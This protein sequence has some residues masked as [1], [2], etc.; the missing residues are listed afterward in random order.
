MLHRR[1]KSLL[2]QKNV[3]GWRGGK[4][5]KPVTTPDIRHRHPALLAL[6]GWYETDIV[7]P[8]KHQALYEEYKASGSSLKITRWALRAG[9]LDDSEASELGKNLETTKFKLSCRHNDLIRLAETSH[10]RSC[11]DGGYG[12]QQ[13]QYLADPDIAVVFIPDAAGKYS[14]RSLA[15]LV[16]E[17][18]G[19]GLV[20]YR[21]YGNGPTEAIFQT[22]DK[23]LPVYQAK[24]L[25][26]YHVDETEFKV[27]PTIHNNKFLSRPVWTD[28][29]GIGWDK[30]RRIKIAVLLRGEKIHFL[31]QETRAGHGPAPAPFGH[32]GFLE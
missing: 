8:E 29:K 4:L 31:K 9:K 26:H 12:Q 32:M 13:M 25:R 22:L 11:M 10:Y 19:F 17:Q 3:P 24:D 5:I 16:M 27:S 15:R 2:E 23:K 30:D 6:E 28:H 21:V 20:M 18:E 7:V 14:W 1:V